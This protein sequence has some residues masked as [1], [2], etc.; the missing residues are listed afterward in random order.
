MNTTPSLPLT[1][2]TG[3]YT[4]PLYGELEISLEGNKLVIDI[5]HFE[6]ATV[7]HW[8]YNTFR[9]MYQHDWDGHALAHFS[10]NTT[11]QVEKISLD[12]LEFTKVKK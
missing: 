8:N 3:K 2:Y 9:G 11:G 5:N 6:K 1:E 10:L 12:G 4:D 7:E